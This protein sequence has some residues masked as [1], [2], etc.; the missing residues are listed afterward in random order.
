[1]DKQIL[2]LTCLVLIFGGVKCQ[3]QVQ[4]D[5][6]VR[7]ED[8]ERENLKSATSQQPQQAAAQFAQAPLQYQQQYLP[9]QYFTHPQYSSAQLPAYHQQLLLSQATQ[10]PVYVP[11]NQPL[12]F[13]VMLIPSQYLLQQNDV[14]SLLSLQGVPQGQSQLKY[15]PAQLQQVAQPLVAGQVK[16]FRPSQQV[17]FAAG[18][19]QF[20]QQ[21]NAYQTVYQQKFPAGAKSTVSPPLKENYAQPASTF[22]YK[23]QQ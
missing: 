7:L 9:Q 1:M 19:Q 20:P 8:I 12:P 22:N 15:R 10:Q 3:N 5:R 21:Y 13:P 11:Q 17:P 2:P 14:N 16:P 23:L 18:Q 4:A 6:Q